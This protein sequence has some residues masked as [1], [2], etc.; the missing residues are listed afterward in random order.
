MVTKNGCLEP[1]LVCSKAAKI[2]KRC[3]L[4]RSR[5]TCLS[6]ITRYFFD[7]R[8]GKCAPF[9]YGRC[10]GNDNNFETLAEC[11][12]VC[13]ENSTSSHHRFTSSLSHSLTDATDA[14][15]GKNE[16]QMSC[17]SCD[18]ICGQPPTVC[19]AVCRP[20]SCGCVEGFLRNRRGTCV[21]RSECD[22]LQFDSPIDDDIC[23]TNETMKACG[24]CDSSCVNPLRA[25]DMVCRTPECG[26]RDGFIRNFENRCVLITDCLVVGNKS[27]ELVCR[28]DN[29]I[30][31]SC[32]ACDMK[33]NEPSV[34]CSLACGEPECGCAN[35]WTAT[36][37][38][39]RRSPA[40]P[41]TLVRTLFALLS[42]HA[43][44]ALVLTASSLFST[45][46]CPV[47]NI[48]LAPEGCVYAEEINEVGCSTAKLICQDLKCGQNEEVKICGACDPT[49]EKPICASS[50]LCKQP[51]CGCIDGFVRDKI[52]TCINA[53]QCQHHAII[54]D[55][56][57]PGIPKV[58]HPKCGL[59]EELKA[60]GSACAPTCTV[61]EPVCE[62]HC[63]IDVCQCKEGYVAF[64]NGSCI[65]LSDCPEYHKNVTEC[66]EHE[67]FTNCGS[68][69]EPT[70]ENTE[71]TVCT[72]QC[73]VDVCQCVKGYVRNSHGKCVKKSQC[74][75]PAAVIEA[76]HVCDPNEHFTACGTEC[77]P[78]CSE[79]FPAFCTDHCVV[80]V[81]QCA[82]GFVRDTNN[83]CVLFSECLEVDDS[84]CGRFEKFQSCG[85]ACEPTCENP[86]PKDCTQ[87]CILDVCQ[88]RAGYVRDDKGKCI[89]KSHCPKKEAPK[90][91]ERICGTHEKFQTCGT[92]CEPTCENQKP[93]F[94]TDHCIV[95]VCQCE[96]SFVRHVSGLCVSPSQC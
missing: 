49:C 70:C 20:A 67:A 3:L 9:I 59:N 88:C 66:G 91:E 44:M 13:I 5:G 65:A 10:K 17:G 82:P 23:G 32:G 19:S 54:V 41:T 30:V 24:A 74:K 60:C 42:T 77:E 63:I 76:N 43:L 8:I 48:A 31:H 11:E 92:A 83:K 95:D 61:P 35:G 16:E 18:D 71:P 73:V 47:V 57:V 58:A 80:D 89:K 51:E 53:T 87:Q 50:L 64:T 46:N 72:L 7:N 62:A 79:P 52:G 93:A 21:P 34:A 14:K 4:P 85:T 81:C 6:L 36:E 94:C 26:C 12:A 75:A 27:R 86:E 90:N 15:C 56:H 68:A 45:T 33:C 39:C 25:C 37:S 38:A 40:Q 84:S 78:T 55:H 69:C 22:H 28:G 96:A 2:D 29:E 1:Q